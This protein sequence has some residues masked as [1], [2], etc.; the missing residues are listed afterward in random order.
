MSFGVI[1][2]LILKSV[3][4]LP[5]VL[6][7]TWGYNVSTHVFETRILEVRAINTHFG[8]RTTGAGSADL[9]ELA[10][11]D[12]WNLGSAGEYVFPTN[13]FVADQWHWLRIIYNPEYV[14]PFTYYY[15]INS[16][17]EPIAWINLDPD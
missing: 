5:S 17:T 4:P 13:P 14:Y 16:A 7:F 9:D 1:G 3:A 6:D 12:R 10:G 15:A 2:K 8:S 11:I